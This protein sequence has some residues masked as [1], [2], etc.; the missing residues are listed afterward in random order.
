[1]GMLCYFFLWNSVRRL[2]VLICLIS[3]SVMVIM[4]VVVK[5]VVMLVEWIGVVLMIFGVV[6]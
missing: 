3:C 6:R 5:N 1:M 2:S 4:S